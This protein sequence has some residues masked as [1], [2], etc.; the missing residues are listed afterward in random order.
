MALI[1]DKLGTS[2]TG[3]ILSIG[4]L[5]LTLLVPMGMV[6]SVITERSTVYRSAEE[7]ITGSWGKD[8]TLIDP[9]LTVDEHR[10]LSYSNGAYSYDY[11]YR[12]LGPEKL[13][14]NGRI[15][16]QLRQRGIFRVPVYTGKIYISGYF[17]LPSEK[18][19]DIDINR[20]AKIQVLLNTGSVKK[21][22][23]LTWNGKMNPMTAEKV[24]GSNVNAVFYTRLDD[25]P[26]N[27]DNHYPFDLTLELTG[28]EAL[29]FL[30]RARQSDIR[31]TSNWDSPS[32]FGTRLP[33]SY[34]INDRG[35]S[36][37]WNAHNFFSDLGHENSD[38]IAPGWFSNDAKFGVKFIQPVDTYQLVTR[39]AK[40]AVLFLTLI[41]TGYL[42]FEILCDLSLHPVQYLFIGFANCIFYLLLLSLAEH[43]DFN[44]A[45]FI[46]S[47]S[48]SLLIALYSMSILKDRARGILIFVKL[49]VLYTFLFIT[50]KS[51]DYALLSGSIGLF[52]I[53]ALVMYFTRNFNWY[54]TPAVK[55]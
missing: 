25:L 23:V 34:D 18:K 55:T 50:L 21:P 19:V 49:S 14:V 27:D 8:I 10:K 42:L 17:T 47:L 1:F 9:V 15:E 32:F 37:E 41:F 48:S 3:K 28:S 33:A 54:R 51:E 35:F 52:V 45:Y 30:S 31:L 40:Y 39:A 16:T 7:D 26:A 44:V 38:T 13:T 11:Q 20:E 46:S 5:V 36:A 2:I 4:L 6:E 22:P 53:L 43:I 24:A 12:N 29:T